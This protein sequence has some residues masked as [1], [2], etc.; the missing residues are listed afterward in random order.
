MLW[1]QGYCQ[2]AESD[3]PCSNLTD[4]ITPVSMDGY[5]GVL[6]KFAQDT[7]AFFHIGDRVYAVAVWRT[8]SD[9]STAPYGGAVRL[10]KAFIST[11]HLLPGGPVSSAPPSTESSQSPAPS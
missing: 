11:M 6:V 5:S 7:Q 10:L 9:P 3:S 8:D 2:L 1:I 4:L